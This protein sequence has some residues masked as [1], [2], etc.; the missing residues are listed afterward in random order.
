MNHLT[1]ELVE[2]DSEITRVTLTP[3]R[4]T[5]KVGRKH[6]G[7]GF[8]CLAL[9]ALLRERMGDIVRSWRGTVRCQ[10]GGETASITVYSSNGD[11]LGYSFAKADL[12]REAGAYA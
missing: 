9:A 6:T 8:W 2:V 7:H 12:E 3:D 10:P 4:T 5:V 11:H 1:V